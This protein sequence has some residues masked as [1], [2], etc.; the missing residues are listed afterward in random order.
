MSTKNQCF[1]EERFGKRNEATEINPGFY[2]S[3][4]NAPTR[5]DNNLVEEVNKKQCFTFKIHLA[6]VMENY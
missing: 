1:Y 5:R 6:H 4:V 3:K 2:L